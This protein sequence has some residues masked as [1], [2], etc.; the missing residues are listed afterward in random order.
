MHP[1]IKYNI[2]RECVHTYFVC[3]SYTVVHVVPYETAVSVNEGDRYATVCASLT[4]LTERPVDITITTVDDT[5]IS[6]C[7]PIT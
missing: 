5:A 1:Y 2:V 6:K 3:S 7:N 4:G